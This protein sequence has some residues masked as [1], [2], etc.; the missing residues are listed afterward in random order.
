MTIWG[1]YQFIIPTI[2]PVWLLVSYALITLGVL[3]F[4]ASH[5]EHYIRYGI[6]LAEESGFLPV[7]SHVDVATVD[8][9]VSLL[10][11]DISALQFLAYDAKESYTVDDLVRASDLSAQTCRYHLDNL[12]RGGFA[13]VG[14]NFDNLRYPRIVY[15]LTEEGRA[16]LAELGRLP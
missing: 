4:A 9:P 14:R 13:A 3:S 7:A 1:A 6:R 10:P 5:R 16:K 8:D 11:D 12:T 15:Y 2:P